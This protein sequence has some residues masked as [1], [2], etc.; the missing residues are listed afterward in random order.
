VSWREEGYYVINF[1]SS[2]LPEHTRLVL[3]G[4]DPQTPQGPL[5]PMARRP[6]PLRPGQ[7]LNGRVPVSSVEINAGQQYTEE[8][9]DPLPKRE[10]EAPPLTLSIPL[11]VYDSTLRDDIKSAF[12]FNV[13]YNNK[14][15]AKQIA[16]DPAAQ[17]VDTK[18][19]ISDALESQ[20]LYNNAGRWHAMM[21][22]QLIK[23]VPEL[24]Q[25]FIKAIDDHDK[26]AMEWL[27]Y[28]INT[29]ETIIIESLQKLSPD[30]RKRYTDSWYDI[31]DQQLQK[32]PELENKLKKY[33]DKNDTVAVQAIQ[34]KLDATKAILVKSVQ[35]ISPGDRKVPI[36]CD[37][38]DAKQKEEIRCVP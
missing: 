7:V 4:L 30:L 33:L 25:K 35:I 18:R 38:L 5:G 6:P 12:D 34:E 8:E 20:H 14:D 24:E 10:Q 17:K 16:D 1:D 11:T 22:E 37:W 9:G 26:K 28:D 32:I 19:T 29:T 15:N 23:Y 36:K 3:S 21:A 27:P 13:K 31:M 2:L